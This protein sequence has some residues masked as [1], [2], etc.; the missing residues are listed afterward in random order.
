MHLAPRN[1]CLA[2]PAAACYLGPPRPRTLRYA[3]FY[4]ACVL[5]LAACA[6]A[7]VAMLAPYKM[8]PEM[9][10]EEPPAD[11]RR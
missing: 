9:I 6:L 10:R 3:L 11:A 2:T 4:A 5:I 7:W 8:P 1:G